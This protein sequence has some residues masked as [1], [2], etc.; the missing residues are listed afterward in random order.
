MLCNYVKVCIHIVCKLSEMF[1]SF[2]GMNWEEKTSGWNGEVMSNYCSTGHTFKNNILITTFASPPPDLLSKHLLTNASGSSDLNG[3]APLQHCVC[4][5]LGH[6]A[7][8]VSSRYQL[9]MLLLLLETLQVFNFHLYDMICPIKHCI[10][11]AVTFFNAFS[12][13]SGQLQCV[14]SGVFCVGV[15]CSQRARLHRAYWKWGAS[16]IVS[17]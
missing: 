8:C 12:D 9:A 10:F 17:I 2:T 4:Y 1:F 14:W 5:G 11:N 6:F 16:H 15:W 13:S 7:S 3:D